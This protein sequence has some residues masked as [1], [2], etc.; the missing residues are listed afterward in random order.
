MELRS[1]CILPEG[2]V[3]FRGQSG[4]RPA[5]GRSHSTA[6]RRPGPHPALRPGHRRRQPRL[7]LQDA[8]P[9]DAPRVGPRRPAHPPNGGPWPRPVGATMSRTRANACASPVQGLR[10][11]GLYPCPQGSADSAGC[12]RTLRA[13][14]PLGSVQWTLLFLNHRAMKM[15]PRHSVP[16]S[17]KSTFGEVLKNRC[18]VDKVHRA[19]SH[20]RPKVS[21]IPPSSPGTHVGKP[22]VPS[23]P[24]APTARQG[25]GVGLRRG[26]RGDERR[27]R[28][29]RAGAWPAGH[30]GPPLGGGGVDSRRPHRAQQALHLQPR[31]PLG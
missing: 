23:G 7:V 15:A 20:G 8:R 14:P 16:K 5:W 26:H 18:P 30:T 9:G 6:P 31:V 12:R 24:P 27:P 21:R 1:R 13:P 22:N 2:A 4:K 10:T 19:A 25:P 3:Y 17:K 29:F 11:G 28:P